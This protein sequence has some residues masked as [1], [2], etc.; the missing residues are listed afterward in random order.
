MDS[1]LKALGSLTESEESDILSNALSFYAKNKYL[2]PKF[3]FVV[4]WRF[5]EHKIDHS[6]SF[7][8]I[9]LKKHKYQQDLAD[10]PTDR[11]HLIWPALSKHQRKL[12]V[13]YG[14][15]PPNNA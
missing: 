9:S 6:S 14:H 12:A 13:S 5:A 1:C 10:M 15:R 11:V 4:F 7:F 3:A 8:K 2:T